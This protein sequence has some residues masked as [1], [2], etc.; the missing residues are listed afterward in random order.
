MG[1]SEALQKIGMSKIEADVYIE[2]LKIGEAK[3]SQIKGRVSLP[4]ATIYAVLDSLIKNGNVAYTLRGGVKYFSAS[5][6]SKILQIMKEKEREFQVVIPELESMK[7]ALSEKP[8][9]EVYEGKEGLKTIFEKLKKERPKEDLVISGP[10]ILELLNF[11]F[12]HHLSEKGALGI[13]TRVI[14]PKWKESAKYL[15]EY[16]K[17][18]KNQEIRFLSEQIPI[19][20]R[21]EL[22]NDKVIITNVDKENFISIYIKD[23]RISNT[24]KLLFEQLW[25]SAKS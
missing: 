21:I 9:V 18:L 17:E 15:E 19:D 7:R 13:K 2:L 14:G 16:K 11:Y 12:P 6:P 25:K 24:L 1:I 23:K 5:D 22:F 8:S 4:R 10:E 3:V 20:S